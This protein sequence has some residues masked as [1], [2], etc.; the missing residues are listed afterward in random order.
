MYHET[1]NFRGFDCGE[2]Q[3]YIERQGFG[4]QGG[5]V[6]GMDGNSIR[7]GNPEQVCLGSIQLREVEVTFSFTTEEELRAF[8][9]RFR[10]AFLRGGA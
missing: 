9:K 1:V 10:R 4:D 8:L 3:Q 2:F 5:G 6:F 7:L